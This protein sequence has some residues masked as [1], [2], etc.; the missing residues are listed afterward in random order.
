MHWLTQG[1]RLVNFRWN[2]VSLWH[3]SILRETTHSSVLAW[4]IPG[5]GKPGGLPSMGLH[6]VGHDW[7][8]LAAAAEKEKISL[9]CFL[10][11]L[12]RDKNVWHLQAISSIWR[13]LAF[14]PVTLS[15]LCRSFPLS[16]LTPQGRGPCP[17][18][19]CILFCLYHSPYLIPRRLIC[20]SE[21]WDHL[22][23]F[24]RC[25]VGTECGL[26]A[27]FLCHLPRSSLI[28]FMTN[29]ILYSRL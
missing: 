21:V 23:V 1:L 6:R 3:H 24:W 17:Q 2:Q 10:L 22:P 15:L 27:L 14:L 20:L 5:T 13:P 11:L 8:N 19:L 28:F 18:I 9:V 26:P 12:K 29:F 4:R 25:S 16:W 7:G